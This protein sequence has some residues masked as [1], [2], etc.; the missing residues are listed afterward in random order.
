MPH[1]QLIMNGACDGSGVLSSCTP[2]FISCGAP[3]A[4]AATACHG[5]P[6]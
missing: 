4:Q 2:H 3:G 1:F 5:P 6:D